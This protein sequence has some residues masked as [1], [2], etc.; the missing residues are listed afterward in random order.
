MRLFG[1]DRELAIVRAALERARERAL[2]AAVF[3]R[4]ASGIGKTALLDRAAEQARAAGWFVASGACHEMQSGVPFVFVNRLVAASIQRLGAQAARYVGGLEERLSAFDATIANLLGL[5]GPR[6]PLSADEYR[7][8]LQRFFEGL[9]VDQAICLVADDLQWIDAESLRSLKTLLEHAGGKPLALLA[10]QRVDEHGT[11]GIEWPGAAT[12]ELSALDAALAREFVRAQLPEA[13]EAVIETIVAQGGGRPL[14][15]MTLC[16]DVEAALADGTATPQS[17]VRSAVAARLR[18][19]PAADREFLQLCALIGEPVEFR[20]LFKLYPQAEDVAARLSGPA[21]VYLQTDGPSLRFRHRAIADAV[22]E[23]VA[24]DVPL[25]L[26][27]LETLG[28][29]EQP[30]LYD[31]QRIAAQHMAL[32]DAEAAFQ[33]YCRIMEA[34]FTRKLWST[35]SEAAERAL[36]L[37]APRPGEQVPFFNQY[38][39]A[40]RDLE[41]SAEATRLLEDIL[42]RP[43]AL[44][45]EPGSALLWSVLAAEL[46]L[47]QG[48]D[49]AFATL[50]EALQVE[51]NPHERM[52]LLASGASLA[53]LAVRPQKA[54]AFLEQLDAEFDDLNDMVASWRE[55]ALAYLASM[56][57]DYA[58]A[59]AHLHQAGLRADSRRSRQTD[60][61]PYVGL[62]IDWRHRGCGIVAA[63]LPAV[64]RATRVEAGDMRYAWGVEAW[65]V[66]ACGDWER[67]EEIAL[68]AQGMNR[69][70]AGLNAM[71][72]A[73]RAMQAGLRGVAEPALHDSLR[74]SAVAA[75]RERRWEIAAQ[76]L[77]WLALLEDDATVRD[78]VRAVSAW[79]CECLPSLST[80]GAMPFAF[81]LAAARFR[82]SGVLERFAR[83]RKPEDR[84]PWS[85]AHWDLAQ[86]IALQALGRAGASAALERAALAF[87][88]LGATCYAAIADVLGGRPAEPSAALLSRLGVALSGNRSAKR[89]RAAADRHGLTPREVEVVRLVA[90]GKTNRQ[91][92]EELVLSERT[93]E[94]HLGNAFGKLQVP[95]RAHLIRWYFE[96]SGLRS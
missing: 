94:V 21:N 22:S 84:S 69:E 33:T 19:M 80:L 24:F 11:P 86:G 25:R 66:Q 77:G 12:L 58:G 55:T 9:A 20:V 31:L 34:A 47:N 50:D 62:V 64:L 39:Q 3:V 70:S 81:A 65:L 67:A 6:P 74:A 16:G 29:F 53:A 40:L 92:A 51:T 73:V 28:S 45:G 93:V 89:G 1:R 37:R 38:A 90:A 32:G 85:L 15:L 14:E 78:G 46:W 63:Q 7:I 88:E 36:A 52:Q 60:L 49:D 79:L 91:I 54:L 82:E 76:L 23:S 17:V 72:L 2:P 96:Q 68:R 30:E 27:L 59:R 8:V 44:R 35:L 41:R 57:G 4:G 5:S 71:F 83:D 43:G 95:S 10:A 75:W 18:A 56:W 61:L 26:K 48:V 42:H 87:G 13:S